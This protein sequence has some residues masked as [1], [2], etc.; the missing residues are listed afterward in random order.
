MKLAKPKC[1]ECGEEA[2][3]TVEQLLGCADIEIDGD[4]DAIYTDTEVAWE[5]SE[6]VRGPGGGIM[7]VCPEGHSW[8][9]EVKFTEEELSAAE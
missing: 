1:P 4:G 6:S 5:H 8:E 3:S 9:S 7:L 2:R